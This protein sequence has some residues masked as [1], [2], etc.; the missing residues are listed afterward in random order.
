[1]GK[2]R[3]EQIELKKKL[4]AAKAKIDIGAIYKHYKSDQKIYKVI[5]LA[6]MEATNQL[7]V[8][9]KSQYE[10][11]LTFIRP[12]RVWLQTVE[13]QGKAVPRFTKI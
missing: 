7:C 4:D 13:W 5:D 9:Y 3:E 1:M 6:F 2:T 10:E 12:V 8:I 11:K